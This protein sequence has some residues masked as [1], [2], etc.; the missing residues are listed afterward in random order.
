MTSFLELLDA[1]FENNKDDDENIC[2]ITFEPL[3][4][5]HVKLYCGHCFNYEAIYN[6][7]YHQ[8]YNHVPTSIKRLGKYQI[9]CPYCRNVQ[10]DLLPPRENFKVVKKV[11]T[12]IE[13]TM[14][15]HMCDHI[16][17]RG[18]KKGTICGVR[19]R[20]TKCKKHNKTKK[21]CSKRCLFILTRG[22]R[23]NKECGRNIK[24][25][26]RCSSHIGK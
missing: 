4:D 19:S 1:E 18:A 17:K 25:D 16:F 20:E 12:P 2:L 11:N 10:T 15:E 13:M 5:N 26:E 6:E 24:K 21:T 3:T 22:P 9:K 8:K 23:K 7:V 14:K